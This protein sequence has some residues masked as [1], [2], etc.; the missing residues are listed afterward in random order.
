MINSEVAYLFG[1]HP[2]GDGQAAGA[3]HRVRDDDATEEAAGG[4]HR[5]L[6]TEAGQSREVDWR[7]WRREKPL[8]GK[9]P[10]ARRQLFQHHW[11]RAA[12]RR[13]CRLPRRVHCQI[14]TGVVTSRTSLQ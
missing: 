3:E 13:R 4:Q 10:R 6:F 12:E 2:V 11:R 7:S 1:R 14:Q 8:D 5:R 9:R